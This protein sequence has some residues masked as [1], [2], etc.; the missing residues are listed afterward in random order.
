MHQSVFIEKKQI[1]SS[2]KE[3]C[4]YLQKN[5]ESCLVA[6]YKSM[7]DYGKIYFIE[8]LK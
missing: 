5:F 8:L 4:D 7:V 6:K 3:I 2:I 1:D